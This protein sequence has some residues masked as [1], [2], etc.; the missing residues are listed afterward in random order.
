[1][2]KNLAKGTEVAGIIVGSAID[3]KLRSA[4]DAHPSSNVD[5]V[6]YE[7]RVSVRRV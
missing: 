7:S 6:E 3:D 2:R 5:L 4:R 1:V